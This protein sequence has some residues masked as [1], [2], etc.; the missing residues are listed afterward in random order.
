MLPWIIIFLIAALIAGILG[1]AIVPAAI[2]SVV[3][4]LFFLFL[5]LFFIFLALYITKR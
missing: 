2:V 3:K 1:F 5:I 4:F